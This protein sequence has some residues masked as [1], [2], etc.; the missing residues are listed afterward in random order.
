MQWKLKP[1]AWIP[2]SAKMATE[3]L[4]VRAANS[5][6]SLRYRRKKEKHTPKTRERHHLAHQKSGNEC[7]RIPPYRVA[8]E[9]LTSRRESKIE[10]R[11]IDSAME[12]MA[13]QN[14][15]QILDVE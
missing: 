9:I 15:H 2:T 3:F 6:L 4:F 7:L 10:T 1:E 12:G 14:T 11:Q 8:D 13:Q 5:G